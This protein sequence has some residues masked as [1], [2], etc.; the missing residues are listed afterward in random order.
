[1]EQEETK[2]VEQSARVKE[3]IKSDDFKDLLCCLALRIKELDTVRDIN[4]KKNYNSIAIEQL[5]KKMAIE[6]IEQ[7]L[8]DILGVASYSDFI[9]NNIEKTNDIIKRFK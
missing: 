1:M 3:L 7:W 5:A 8:D 6:I 2:K 4:Y 9:D